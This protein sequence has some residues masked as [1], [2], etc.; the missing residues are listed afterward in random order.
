MKRGKRQGG[1]GGRP[2][3]GEAS[4]LRDQVSGRERFSMGREKRNFLTIYQKK[5]RWNPASQI[6]SETKTGVS[7]HFQYGMEKDYAK[8]RTRRN[9]SWQIAV[10]S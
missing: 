2:R 3:E 8:K 10:L 1:A 7:P 4:C 9:L 6:W 5:K